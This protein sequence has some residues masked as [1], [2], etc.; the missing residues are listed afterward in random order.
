MRSCKCIFSERGIALSCL[1]YS[2][3]SPACALS[4]NMVYVMEL[5]FHW[6]YGIPHVSFLSQG[7]LGG[8]LRCR[9]YATAILA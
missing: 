2:G 6:R 7:M 3:Q 9:Q 8:L 4:L 1:F 5:S